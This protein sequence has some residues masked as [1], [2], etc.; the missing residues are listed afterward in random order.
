MLQ[1]SGL[2]MASLKSLNPSLITAL[3]SSFSEFNVEVKKMLKRLDSSDFKLDSFRRGGLIKD[4]FSFIQLLKGIEESFVSKKDMQP[5]LKLLP[6]LKKGMEAVFGSS[7]S[8][9]YPFKVLNTTSLCI[10]R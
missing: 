5:F 10:V 6:D 1:S 7:Y 8:A 9:I 4:L 3:G 2:K